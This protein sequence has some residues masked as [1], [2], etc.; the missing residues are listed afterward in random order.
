MLQLIYCAELQVIQACFDSCSIAFRVQQLT[1]F[2]F[3]YIY[4]YISGSFAAIFKPF[5]LGITWNF[6]SPVS[7]ISQDQSD[8]SPFD[9]ALVISCDPSFYIFPG[10]ELLSK[11]QEKKAKASEDS[12]S[13]CLLYNLEIMFTIKEGSEEEICKA[14]NKLDL[15]I[16]SFAAFKDSYLSELTWKY[17]NG[18]HFCLL[19]ST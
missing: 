1:L 11:K 10:T 17:P 14:K 18:C 9:R 13:L 2:L 7:L 6:K 8:L 15:F 19:E 5:G 12:C 4:I 16:F 3:L